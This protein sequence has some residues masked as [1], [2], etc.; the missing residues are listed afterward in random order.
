MKNWDMVKYL[1]I[2]LVVII[3]SIAIMALAYSVV[4]TYQE[5]GQLRQ[6]VSAKDGEVQNLQSSVAAIRLANQAELEQLQANISDTANNVRLNTDLAL[7]LY[8]EQQRIKTEVQA[9]APAQNITVIVKDKNR[10]TASPQYPIQSRDKQTNNL[11]SPDD[12]WQPTCYVIHDGN[13]STE[14]CMV[15]V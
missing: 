9:T 6:E 1:G 10:P 3:F 12:V 5:A 2:V 8:E 14:V 4:K 15:P 11:S 7:K 13:V